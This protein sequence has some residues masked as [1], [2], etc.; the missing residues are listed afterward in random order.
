MEVMHRGV[1]G[2]VEQ[3]GHLT[4]SLQERAFDD[5]GAV[6]AASDMQAQLQAAIEAGVF[7]LFDAGEGGEME[8][9]LDSA[10][11][12]IH[13][14]SQSAGK[15]RLSSLLSSLLSASPPVTPGSPTIVVTGRAVADPPSHTAIAMT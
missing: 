6:E 8:A 12:A 7:E 9:A 1:R 4:A 2:L 11:D 14:W 3:A 15:R 5:R 13:E 10:A